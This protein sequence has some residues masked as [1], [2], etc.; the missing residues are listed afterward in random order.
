MKTKLTLLAVIPLFMLSACYYNNY[1]VSNSHY[2]TQDTTV[3]YYT[4]PTIEHV[5]LEPIVPPSTLPVYQA[6]NPVEKTVPPSKFR[7]DSSANEKKSSEERTS[8]S[9]SSQNSS[10]QRTTGERSSTN[11]ERRR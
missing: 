4:E 2:E 7:P 10:S 8:S 6:P 1:S 9:R 5:P 3:Y 11:G